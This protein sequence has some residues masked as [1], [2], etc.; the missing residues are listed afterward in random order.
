M[1]S[2]IWIE[3]RLDLPGGGKEMLG[4]LWLVPH[5]KSS[6]VSG[7][8]SPPMSRMPWLVTLDEWNLLLCNVLAIHSS[9]PR[10]G[11][12]RSQEFI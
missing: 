11:E 10:L 5:G 8:S 7:E 6:D 2:D 9:Q 3:Q 1:S 4:M 12:S